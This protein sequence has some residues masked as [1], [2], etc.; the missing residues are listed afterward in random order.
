LNYTRG[1]RIT[2]P[3]TLIKEIETMTTNIASAAGLFAMT[4][5]MVLALVTA[6]AP[7]QAN[8]GQLA[9]ET[10]AQTVG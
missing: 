10:A 9:A 8:S 3:S 7:A 6:G 5:L 2:S 1:K 4:L